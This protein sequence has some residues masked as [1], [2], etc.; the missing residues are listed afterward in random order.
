MVELLFSIVRNT[1]AI[2]F[3]YLLF[4]SLME[5]KKNGTVLKILVL[6]LGIGVFLRSL[7]FT[8]KTISEL[9]AMFFYTSRYPIESI[10]SI[11]ESETGAISFIAVI[12][13]YL[14]VFMIKWTRGNRSLSIKSASIYLMVMVIPTVSIFT[15]FYSYLHF[16]NEGIRGAVSLYFWLTYY[17]QMELHQKEI[18]TI[19]HDLQNQ[20]IALSTSFQ[21]GLTAGENPL[22]PLIEQLS[23]QTEYN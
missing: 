15:L 6:L 21:N 19:K 16:D 4:E 20:L 18:R 13:L 23:H 8:L 7:V 12:I 3:S 10:D 14:Y 22:S 17:Q 11:A 1:W 5:K 9:T 2:A